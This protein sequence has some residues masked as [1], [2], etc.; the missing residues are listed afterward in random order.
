MRPRIS[1]LLLG[2]ALLALAGVLALTPSKSE[3]RS[4]ESAAYRVG[5][6][7][8]MSLVV[9]ARDTEYCGYHT[10]C[11]PGKRTDTILYVHLRGG[12]AEILA[13]PRD[14]LVTYQGVSGKVNAIYGRMGAD[15]LRRAVEELLGV[16]VEHYLILTFD[17][18]AK[19]VDAVDGIEVNLPEPMRYTDRAAGLF[20][21][22]PAGW[23]KMDGKD[24]V[25][26]MRF[27]HDAS[28]DYTR[29]DRIKG[30]LSQVAQKAQSPRYWLRLPEVAQEV[31][32][33]IETDL[34]LPEALAFLPYARGLTLRVA[35][36]PTYEE[37]NYLLS[38]PA[39]RASFVQGFL[40]LAQGEATAV[41]EGRV[42]L[43][44]QGGKGGQ[45][46]EGFAQ[47]ALPEPE[48]REENLGLEPGVYISSSALA[49]PRSRQVLEL[50]RYYS[51][52]LH[53]PLIGRFRPVVEGYDAVAVLDPPPP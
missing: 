15:G 32:H 11:G 9:A 29:L 38:D 39:Q 40:G 6:L 4:G 37:G 41:P 42:L 31:W 28:G 53:L 22:F 26:Y 30:V 24:A 36:L 50:G 25:K 34:N 16:P 46:L 14:L 7:P 17:S 23:V 27:R 44:N 20:I 33:Q 35:S 10:A 18:V 12:Q 5:P 47:M 43:V 8:E 45:W 19:L 13:I 48:L 2:L 3:L 49:S 51:D 52:L 1:L 21:D